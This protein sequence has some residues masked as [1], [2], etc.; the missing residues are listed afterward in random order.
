MELLPKQEEVQK[1][2]NAGLTK[3]FFKYLRYWKWF[4]ASV[5][6]CLALAVFYLKTASPVYEV[7]AKI[8]LNNEQKD[9]GNGCQYAE[10]H[11]GFWPF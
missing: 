3:A 6:V 1:E 11:Q 7:K 4:V 9:Q 5:V 8:L 2:N 10:C